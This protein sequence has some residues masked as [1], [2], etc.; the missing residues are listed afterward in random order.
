MQ[1]RRAAAA[2]TLAA[3]STIR[4]VRARVAIATALA[5]GPFA[6][7]RAFRAPLA[8]AAT[9]AASLFVVPRAVHA[10]APALLP[11]GHWA[12]QAV[13]TLHGLGALAGTVDRGRR[14]LTVGEAA[15]LIRGADA[16]EDPTA[17]AVLARARRRL[18]SD[19]PSTGVPSSRGATFRLRGA[20]GA[21]A[22]VRGDE[23]GTRTGRLSSARDADGHFIPVDEA[24][25]PPRPDGVRA[26]PD[27]FAALGNDRLALVGEARS[28][29]NSDVV[30]AAY[31]AATAGP[32]SFWAGR[33]APGY[34]PGRHGSQVLS[35]DREVLGGGLAT[36]R[37]FRFPWFL[38]GLG[39]I[40]VETFLGLLERNREIDDPLL[41]GMRASATPHPRFG[42]GASRAA[43]FGGDGNEGSGFG[44]FLEILVLER[45]P[46]LPAENQTGALDAWFRPPL[47]GLPLVA[48]VEWGSDDTAGGLFQV[49]GVVAGLEVPALPGLA[50][51]GVAVEAAWLAGQ[52]GGNGPW[53]WHGFFPA[54]WAV[55][56]EPLGHPLGGEGTEF[57]LGLDVRL[58]ETT[59]VSVD[60]FRRDRGQDNLYAPVR[61]GSSNGAELKVDFQPT[62]LG[63][64]SLLAYVEEGDG[65]TRGGGTL[66][67]RV[68]F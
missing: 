31:A 3:M 54:G 14:R 52:G 9:L 2:A 66:A 47:G 62:R 61:E 17:A 32:V 51:L 26:E 46:G 19:F 10:Q 30:L 33:S 39:D 21:S 7:T 35:G 45:S 29:A 1:C 42:F 15:R 36:T 6:V 60:L 37:P 38:E 41:W 53:Y 67:G 4:T 28:T 64:I 58:L 50:P 12:A 16:G 18:E 65:W 13:W 68:R 40:Q 5:A 8:I 56:G 20:A 57:L 44:H 24:P 48:W 23:V 43:M 11:P 59:R 55:K 49:P 27:G 22:I 63:E 25:S 34:G